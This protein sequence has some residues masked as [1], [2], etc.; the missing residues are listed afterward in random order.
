[1]MRLGRTSSRRMTWPRDGMIVRHR[2]GGPGFF[3]CRHVRNLLGSLVMGLLQRMEAV[4]ARRDLSPRTVEVYQAWVRRFLAFH[5]T[6]AGVAPPARAAR[7]GRRG[8]PHR[9]SPGAGGSARPA[10]IR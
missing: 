2:L 1:M 3:P 4:A 10:R 6:A 9:P 8:V 5:R 7:G